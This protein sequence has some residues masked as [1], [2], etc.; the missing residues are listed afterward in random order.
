[1]HDLGL[2]LAGLNLIFN[3]E[4]IVLGGSV[5]LKSMIAKKK[6]LAEII[7]SH[8]L[9]GKSPILFDADINVSVAR[10]AVRLLI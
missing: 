5:Y 10:G 9:S 4:V 2:G 8:S 1:M 6:E 7:K 3:P